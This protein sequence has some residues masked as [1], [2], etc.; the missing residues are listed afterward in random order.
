M[1]ISSYFKPNSGGLYTC[2]QTVTPYL[3]TLYIPLVLEL[4]QGERSSE[5]LVACAYKCPRNTSM[6][7]DRRSLLI[8]TRDSK[9]RDNWEIKPHAISVFHLYKEVSTIVIRDL[10]TLP[11][12]GA[13][14][15]KETHNIRA[16]RVEKTPLLCVHPQSDTRQLFHLSVVYYTVPSLLLVHFVG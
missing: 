9:S 1:P 12:I 7:S 16:R 14:V 3:H 6:S 5:V 13:R 11:T 4:Y 15:G 2:L 10:H 8:F